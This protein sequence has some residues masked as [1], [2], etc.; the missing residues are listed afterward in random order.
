MDGPPPAPL[1]VIESCVMKHVTPV[2]ASFHC[3]KPMH[4]NVRVACR[5]CAFLSGSFLAIL[6][7]LSIYDEDFLQVHITQDRSVFWYIG[8]HPSSFPFLLFGL[9]S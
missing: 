3:V 1:T 2:H 7:C 8:V 4:I 5:F 9:S 6:V